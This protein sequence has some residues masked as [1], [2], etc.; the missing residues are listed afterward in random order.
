MA[1]VLTNGGEDWICA[2]LV[3]G[4]ASSQTD[5]RWVAWGTGAGTAAKAD[6]ALFTEASEARV[7]GAVTMEGT[8][9]AAS[10]QVVG[11]IVADGTK[12]IT[13]AGNFTQSSGVSLIVHGDFTDINV[14]ASDSVQF[15]IQINPA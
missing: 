10:Y 12:T 1:T 14:D 7:A 5:G 11:T 8:S 15:T 6:A 9:S 13:N 2:R 4:D 3:Q